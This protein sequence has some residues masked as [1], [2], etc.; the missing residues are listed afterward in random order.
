MK[1][2]QKNRAKEPLQ[3]VAKVRCLWVLLTDRNCMHEKIK[4]IKHGECLLSFSSSRLLT[5]NLNIKHTK[6][7]CSLPILVTVLSKEYVCDRF[8]AVIA[9]SN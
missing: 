6:L 5:T 9:G 1:T 7:Y 3:T 2:S 8:I 4:H